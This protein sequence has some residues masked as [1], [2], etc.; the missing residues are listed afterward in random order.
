MVNLTIIIIARLNV[1]G[2]YFIGT[3]GRAADN[4]LV[5]L[6]ASLIPAGFI[7][8]III[9]TVI[10]AALRYFRHTKKSKFGI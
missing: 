2:N 7:M 5:I 3:Y 6:I 1:I 4:L 9:V 8:I 10:V